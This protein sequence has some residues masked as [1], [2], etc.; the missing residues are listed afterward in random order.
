[1]AD[2]IPYEL[3][4]DL[5]DSPTEIHEI[6]TCVYG[7]EHYPKGYV[8]NSPMPGMIDGAWDAEWHPQDGERMGPTRNDFGPMEADEATQRDRD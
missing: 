5:A 7:M 6:D 1:M 3:S 8:R 2:R 4:T